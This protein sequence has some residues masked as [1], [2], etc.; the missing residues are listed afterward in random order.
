MRARLSF[1][2]AVGLFLL[3]PPAVQAQPSTGAPQIDWKRLKVDDTFRSEGVAAA[4]VNRDG[5]MDVMIGDLWYEAPD[6]HI[7][8]I[9]KPGVY[10]GAKGYSPSFA[11]WAYDVNGDGWTDLV[12]VGFPGDPCHWYENPQKENTHWKQ[13]EIWHSACNETP[14]FLDITGDGKPELIM[15]SQPTGEIGYLEIPSKAEVNEKWKW[16]AVSLPMSI[17]TFKYYHGLGVGDLNLDGRP[18]ILIPDGWWE[19]PQELGKGPW[20]YHPLGLSVDGTPTAFKAAD[21]YAD[22][23]DLDGDQDILASS[24]HE[25]GIWWFE[26]TGSKETPVFKHHHLID[27]TFTQTHALNYADINGD[28]TKDLITGKRF[29]AHGPKGDIDPLGEVV[30]Y[31]YEIHKKKGAKP[32]FIA[33]KIPAGLDTG[34]GTQFQVVDFDGDKNLDIVL[35]NKKG[36]N[37]LLQVR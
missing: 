27:G 17:G 20:E 7:H 26:N 10:D 36:T 2:V 15:G 34:V 23:L 31:W 35:S 24:A 14:Q 29:Y 4:D 6:W 13:H 19:A 22:D 37:V 21:L 8:E 28:G 1:G 12:C 9:R 11:N 3:L 5:K 33:H 32:Q 18:D 30:M 16:V 25:R